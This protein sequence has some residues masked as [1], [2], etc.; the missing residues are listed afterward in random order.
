MENNNIAILIK[1]AKNLSNKINKYNKK[2]NNT[3]KLKKLYDKLTDAQNQLAQIELSNLP[4]IQTVIKFNDKEIFNQK[5][6]PYVDINWI[7]EHID[8]NSPYSKNTI[9]LTYQDKLISGRTVIA[10]I[11]TN[12]PSL[13]LIAK[14]KKPSVVI[15]TIYKDFKEI[16]G[17]VWRKNDLV[18]YKSYNLQNNYMVKYTWWNP[19][20]FIPDKLFNVVKIEPQLPEVIIINPEDYNKNKNTL[21]NGDNLNNYLGQMI[22]IIP[23]KGTTIAYEVNNCIQ[24]FIKLANNEK[25]TEKDFDWNIYSEEF[26]DEF[27]DESEEIR[28]VMCDS[29]CEPTQRLNCVKKE[30]NE[31][32]PNY[33]PDNCPSEPLNFSLDFCQDLV[34]NE[35]RLKT[36]HY[37]QKSW[38]WGSERLNNYIS[39]VF[40]KNDKMYLLVE[41]SFDLNGYI[42]YLRS[43][44]F[45]FRKWGRR[46]NFKFKIKTMGVY[47][48]YKT[49]LRSTNQFI[50]KKVTNIISNLIL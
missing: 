49:N 9:Q 25:L 45:V 1:N 2:K 29:Q 10:S 8:N 37:Y 48:D 36:D 33:T 13:E 41:G 28:N 24:P 30:N 27:I 38:E 6:P 50:N 3:R 5:I 14:D 21:I 47:E 17:E 20:F 35:L 46:E 23:V 39:T 43:D 7:L 4:K 22:Q 16:L 34:A 26:I 12:K 44:I 32:I 18:N 31:F 42:E 19:N 15:Y 40:I 11:K